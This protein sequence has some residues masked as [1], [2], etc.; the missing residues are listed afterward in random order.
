[1]DRPPLADPVARQARHYLTA[2]VSSEDVSDAWHELVDDVRYWG[3]QEPVPVLRLAHQVV[4]QHQRVTPEA[5]VLALDEVGVCAPPDVAAVLDLEP[6]DAERLVEHVTATMAEGDHDPA[7]HVFDAEAGAVGTRVGDPAADDGQVVATDP[8]GEP[9][10]DPAPDEPGPPRHAVRIGFEDDDV[11][12][13]DDGESPA[14]PGWLRWVG[15][16]LLVLAVV[17]VVGV[18]VGG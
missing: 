10:P 7:I 9:E 8:A 17:I 12:E 2:L 3:E 15:I 1:M 11:I 13:I 6:P 14:A 18:L 5:S 4:L 16:L